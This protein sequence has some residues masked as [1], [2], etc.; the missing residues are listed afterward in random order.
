[1][2]SP[3]LARFVAFDDIDVGFSST[4]R[5]EITAAGIEAF[6][7]LSGDTNPIH[8]S[9]SYAQEA[10]FSGRVAHGVLVAA[11]LSSLFG[12]Q[13]PGPGCFWAKQT[14]EWRLPVFIGD[15]I[16]IRAVVKHKSAGT[17]TLLMR[18]EARNQKEQIVMSGEGAVRLLSS[19]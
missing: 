2:I 3:G 7:T 19:R 11:Y 6:A 10:G 18:V 13:F 14:F 4:L 17:R 12:V 16:E 5:R 1:M 9:D 15:V 8:M